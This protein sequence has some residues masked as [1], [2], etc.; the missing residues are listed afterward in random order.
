VNWTLA[1]RIARYVLEALVIVGCFVV[2]LA[3]TTQ[4]DNVAAFGLLGVIVASIVNNLAR[5]GDGAG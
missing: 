4:A 5:G 1:L 2:I 3:P